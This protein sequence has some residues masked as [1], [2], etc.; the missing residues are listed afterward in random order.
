LVQL[1]SILFFLWGVL[2]LWVG[3]AGLENYFYGLAAQ[4]GMLAGG[5]NVPRGALV[6]PADG[7]TA[8]AQSQLLINFCIDV[9]GYGL[10]A[11]FVAWGLW[12]RSSWVAFWVGALVIG[13]GD[14]AFT[15]CLV[16]PGVIEKTFPVVVGPVLW[17]LAMVVTPI[18]LTRLGAQGA[19]SNSGD[20]V[21][22]A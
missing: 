22:H 9:A 8:L 4:W 6:I 13:M 11:L 16:T 1:G 7:P 3:Y 19:P 18:G 12:A 15:F 14:L 10:L 20:S 17:L 5:V 21:L 2:H